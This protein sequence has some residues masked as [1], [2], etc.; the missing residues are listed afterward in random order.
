LRDLVRDGTG[1]AIALWEDQRDIPTEVLYAHRL[2]PGGLLDAPRPIATP[3]AFAIERVAP[4]PS[5]GPLSVRV[6]LPDDAAASLELIDLAGR[7]LVRRAVVGRGSQ[8]VSLA[9]GS[10]IRPGMYV[11]RLSRPGASRASRIAIVR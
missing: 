2:A 7:V 10:G 9:V 1:G 4:N 11:V 6:A 5:S 8:T 3:T